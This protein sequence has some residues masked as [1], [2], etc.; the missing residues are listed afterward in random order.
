MQTTEAFQLHETIQITLKL[1]A[2]FRIGRFTVASREYTK[3]TNI[4]TVIRELLIPEGQ[5][6][7]IM[8]NSR[9]ADP[10]R[11]LNDGDILAIFPLVGG[12]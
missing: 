5:I 6:G 9:H 11:E 10:D 7:T 2:T 4:A 12:G 8:L 3:G 1:F